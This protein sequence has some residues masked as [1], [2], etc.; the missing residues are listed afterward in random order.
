MALDVACPEH[1]TDLPP[2]RHSEAVPDKV[3][4]FCGNSKQRD[5]FAESRKMNSHFQSAQSFMSHKALGLTQPI[6]EK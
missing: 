5:K 3:G 6:A 2:S 4:Q 1:R